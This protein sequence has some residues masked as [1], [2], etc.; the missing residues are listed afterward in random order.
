MLTA[1]LG[2]KDLVLKTVQHFKVV[3]F[4]AAGLSA[5]SP[6][7][8]S[9]DPPA[10]TGGA[11]AGSAGASNAGHA[12]TGSAGANTGGGD[13]TRGAMYFKTAGGG[14]NLCHGNMGEAGQGPNI[15]SSVKYGIGSWTEAEFLNAI[16]NDIGKGGRMLCQ[17]MATIP[18]ANLSDQGVAD[19]Y[20]FLM[21]TPPT[22]VMDRGSSK[23][24]YICP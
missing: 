20:A 3:C 17:F 18:P 4:L 21:S 23:G 24:T 13:V 8:S 12:G 16:R 1:A 15:S 22:E 11:G 2:S 7:C 14:C 9:S 5:L 10:T 19:I 6:A